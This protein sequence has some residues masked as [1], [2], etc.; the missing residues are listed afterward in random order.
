MRFNRNVGMLLLAAFLIL[1]GLVS[2]FAWQI[3]GLDT[4]LPALAILAGVFIVIGK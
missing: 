3:K 1:Y 4:A 2:L